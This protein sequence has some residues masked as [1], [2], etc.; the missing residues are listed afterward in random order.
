M[1]KDII[2]RP[3]YTE[4]IRPYIGKPVIKILTG[5]RRVGKSYILLQL[6]NIIKETDTE[7][8]GKFGLYA[9]CPGGVYS[10]CR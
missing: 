3:Y 2:E 7:M 5:Q 4:K 8:D 1:N 6:I 9:T 10:I